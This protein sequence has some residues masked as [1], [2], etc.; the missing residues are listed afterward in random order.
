MET[1]LAIHTMEMAT[2]RKA[3]RQ[4]NGAT[5][6]AR[7]SSLWICV[8]DRQYVMC[9]DILTHKLLGCMAYWCPC[10]L[11]GKTHHRLEDPSMITYS[12]FN[13]HVRYMP[14]LSSI[15]Y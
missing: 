1:A 3:Q 10:V 15:S 7:V 8:S 12:T 5:P 13:E 6:S 4:A 2:L 14:P 9:I 11:F